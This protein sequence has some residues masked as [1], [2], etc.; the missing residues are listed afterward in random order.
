MLPLRPDARRLCS[1]LPLRLKSVLSSSRR[2]GMLF[3]L[4]TCLSAESVVV[5]SFDGKVDIVGL[6]VATTSPALE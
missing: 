2:L 5:L 6:L 3:L 4:Q 1:Y